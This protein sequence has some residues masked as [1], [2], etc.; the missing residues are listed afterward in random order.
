MFAVLSMQ[1][2]L[3][4]YVECQ[5]ETHISIDASE[6]ALTYVIIPSIKFTLPLSLIFCQDFILTE[7]LGEYSG[8]GIFTYVF[9]FCLFQCAVGQSSEMQFCVV[10]SETGIAHNPTVQ[11]EHLNFVLLYLFLQNTHDTKLVFVQWPNI[12]S[13]MR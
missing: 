6:N 10:D 2:F 8:I 1:P 7:I 12:C 4:C 5:N 3:I 11:C 9:V 13:V